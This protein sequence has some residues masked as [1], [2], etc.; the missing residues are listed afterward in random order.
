M[1][2]ERV[3][4]IGEDIFC[5]SEDEKYRYLYSPDKKYRYWLEARLCQKPDNPGAILF[6]MLNPGTEK[7]EEGRTNHTTRKNCER[8]A[9]E[10]GYGTLWTCN[11]FAFRACGSDVIKCKSHVGENNDSYILKYA[12]QTKMIVCAWGNAGLRLGRAHDVREML[13]RNGLSCKMHH[14]GLNKPP[15][16]QPKHPMVLPLNTQPIPYRPPWNS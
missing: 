5:S 3:E 14:L 1:Q 7:G 2:T 4:A 12:H 13:N 16:S 6:I 15:K 10:Q 11:L 9:R 8:F